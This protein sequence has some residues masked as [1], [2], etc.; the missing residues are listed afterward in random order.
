MEILRAINTD[1]VAAVRATRPRLFPGLT[2]HEARDILDDVSRSVDIGVFFN[3]VL[4]DLLLHGA[5]VVVDKVATEDM[6]IAIDRDTWSPSA[7]WLELLVLILPE[8]E[9]TRDF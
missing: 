8:T 1:T 3:K 7:S 2:E 4:F 5:F 6:I 9:T